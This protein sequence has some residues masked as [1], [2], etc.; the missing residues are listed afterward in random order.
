MIPKI[1]SLEDVA[2]FSKELILEGTNFHPDDDFA[3]YINIDTNQPAYTPE[4]SELRNKLVNQCFDVCEK[5]NVDIYDFTMEVY[6]KET[7]MD[8]F[9][10]L[11][12]SLEKF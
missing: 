6:L 3:N 4:A 8:R 5:E 10:P 7:G 11:P 2:V 12:S 1:E 9:I